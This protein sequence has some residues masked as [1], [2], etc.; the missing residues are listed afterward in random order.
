MKT[1]RILQTIAVA[2]TGAALAAVT[3]CSAPGQT[4]TSESYPGYSHTQVGKY[5]Y[6]VRFTDTEG[7]KWK[8][9]TYSAINAGGLDACEK[10]G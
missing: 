8:C 2:V 9:F 7:N 5:I 3:A 10:V 6:E 1:K 4:T